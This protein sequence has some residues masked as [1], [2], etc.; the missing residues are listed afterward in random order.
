MKVY[1]PKVSINDCIQRY[2]AA[3]DEIYYCAEQLALHMG[4]D[5]NREYA[6]D[7]LDGLIMRVDD[8]PMDI[9]NIRDDATNE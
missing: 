4:D 3:I 6:K 8:M 2:M 1:K 9:E 7:Y 5:E